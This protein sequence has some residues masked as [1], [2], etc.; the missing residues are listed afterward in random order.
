MRYLCDVTV[1]TFQ[2]FPHK[3]MKWYQQRR[4]FLSVW[5]QVF[6]FLFWIQSHLCCWD[7]RGSS[8]KPL[9]LVCSLKLVW[10]IR[11]HRHSALRLDKIYVYLLKHENVF[12]IDFITII[13]EFS[14]VVNQWTCEKSF[15]SISKLV[16]IENAVL[17]QCLC[18]RQVIINN[19]MC[20]I[21][22]DVKSIE[23]ARRFVSTGG[24]DCGLLN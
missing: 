9:A 16:V 22:V 10:I 8:D 12:L 21:R 3:Q 4:H 20:M 2:W 23:L 14:L 5:R 11:R 17:V 6:L 13:K 24:Q 7:L 15:D 18:N 19:K 1:F